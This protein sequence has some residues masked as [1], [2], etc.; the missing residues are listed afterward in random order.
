MSL[1]AS[2]LM[3][4]GGVIVLLAGVGLLRFSTPYARFHAAGKATPMAFLLAAAGAALELG[5]G[6][7][8]YFMI[9]ASAMTLTLPLGVHMMFRAVYRTTNNDHLVVNEHPANQSATK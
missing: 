4:L 2:V 6:G 1:T 9:A 3:L 8:V 7:R 5:W